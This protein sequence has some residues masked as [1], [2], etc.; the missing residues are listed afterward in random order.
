MGS[1]VRIVLYAEADEA[2][3]AAATAAFDRVLELDAVMSDYR[4]DSELSLLCDRAAQGATAQMGK[5]DVGEAGMIP[6][7]EDLFDVLRR[8][9]RISVLSGGAFDMTVGE[10]TRLW[11]E[12]R[13]QGRLPERSRLDKAMQR[14]GYEHLALDNAAR[15]V[16]FGRPGARL[17]LGGIGKGYAADAA[18]RVLEA[19]GV[20]SYLIDMGGDLLAGE[21]PPG[22]EG[23]RIEIQAGGQCEAITLARAAVATSGDTER[24]IEVDGVRYSHILDPRTGLGLTERL[25]VTVVAPD[26]TDADALASAVSVLGVER[27]AALIES[28]AGVS[29]RI[30]DAEGRIRAAVGPVFAADANGR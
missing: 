4:P 26:A 5:G 17:D 1:A 15:T 20:R 28:L 23:W 25:H 3:F 22:S 11:R 14:V 7:S 30:I 24:F 8:A 27:S 12:A 10:L 18:G 6:V 29:A 13:R 2:A 9:K 19:H 16:R 21:A